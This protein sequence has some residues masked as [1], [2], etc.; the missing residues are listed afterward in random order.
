MTLPGLLPR[1]I[2]LWRREGARAVF[3][4]AMR[5]GMR[6]V[7]ARLLRAFGVSPV[8]TAYGVRMAANWHDL[9]FRLCF[10]GSYGTVFSEFLAGIQRDF[11][12]LDIGAN[13]G[14]Y[15]LVAL[16]NPRCRR[17]VAF[18][19]VG[20]TYALLT[21]NLAHNGVSERAVAV[22]AAVSCREGRAVIRRAP[23]HSGGASLAIESGGT[24]F[25]GEEIDLVDHKMLDA[26]LSEEL[27][28]VVKIDVEGHEAT[29]IGELLKTRALPRISHVYYEVAEK[30]S[31]PAALRDLL[32]GAGLVTLRRVGDGAHHDVLA[33]RRSAP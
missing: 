12:F 7:R 8:V 24:A 31:D 9:T 13:Q 29:V 15:T 26:L 28:L 25:V 11:E 20:S 30:R 10:H 2:A 33:G 23:G 6:P 1:V 19:P 3:V 21:A 5:R 18:E 4:R 14:L 27:P 16:R 32:A 17:A 22:R